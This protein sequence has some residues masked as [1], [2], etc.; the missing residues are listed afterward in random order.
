MKFVLE[1]G[2]GYYICNQSNIARMLR[3]DGVT[4]DAR[5][6]AA[7]PDLLAAAKRMVEQMSNR[8]R[9]GD[10]GHGSLAGLRAAIAKAEGTDAP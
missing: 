1:D 7:A 3:E 9:A 10:P 4:A 2:D 8:S 6:I 5:L